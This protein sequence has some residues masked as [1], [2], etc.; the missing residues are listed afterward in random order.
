MF[1]LYLLVVPFASRAQRAEGDF[2]LDTWSDVILD[3]SSMRM[4]VDGI[5]VY[6]SEL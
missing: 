4:F 5:D 3:V 6:I 1:A 2:N